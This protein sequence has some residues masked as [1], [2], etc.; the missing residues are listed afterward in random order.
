VLK[1]VLLLSLLSDVRKAHRPWE[2][3]ADGDQFRE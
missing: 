3:Q 2:W 1:K